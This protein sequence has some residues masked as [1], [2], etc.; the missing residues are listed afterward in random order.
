M[1]ELESVGHNYSTEIVRKGIHLFSLLIPVLY[2]FLPKSVALSILI[3]LTLAFLL[4]DIARLFSPPIGLLYERLFG[5]LLRPHEQ[6][7]K[8][9]QLNGATYMLL[10]AVLCVWLFPKVIVITAFAILI[11][12]DSAA[13]LVGLRFGRR[14]FLA[15]TLEGTGAFLVTA[16]LV[17][18]V[19]PK[20]AFLPTEYLIGA[21]GAMIGTLVEAGAL[22]IDDNLSIPVSI[23]A[24]MWILYALFLPTLDLYTLDR[25][26]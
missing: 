23:G 6:N 9:R 15:K 17:V 16:L 5:W 22:G 25:L 20:I 13:A 19:A 2:Y 18:A 4:A 24:A 14:P 26:L 12:S 1:S 10:S 21:A 3:P 11:I 8:G 7:R